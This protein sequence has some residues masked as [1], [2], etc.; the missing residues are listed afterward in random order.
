MKQ[1]ESIELLCNTCVEEL[2]SP[3]T[4]ARYLTIKYTNAFT[5]ITMPYAQVLKTVQLQPFYS[6][7]VL[8]Y[9]FIDF[10][11]NTKEETVSMFCRPVQ[12][13]TQD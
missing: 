2:Y 7:F 9:R 11:T 5:S 12:A 4:K 10:H 3:N 6:R 1:I 8:I 13:M